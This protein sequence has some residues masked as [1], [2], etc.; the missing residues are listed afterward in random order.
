MG[1]QAET[2][3][4]ASSCP[5]A[6]GTLSLSGWGRSPQGLADPRAWTWP[7][8]PGATL[9]PLAHGVGSRA[10]MAKSCHGHGSFTCTVFSNL[11]STYIVGDLFINW[12][13]PNTLEICF[14]LPRSPLKPHDCP[15]R[16]GMCLLSFG[17]WPCSVAFFCNIS[18]GAWGGLWDA[19]YDEGCPLTPMG[20]PASAGLSTALVLS[21][22]SSPPVSTYPSW[23]VAAG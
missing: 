16:R 11:K 9:T 8:F 18:S 20:T 10:R 3:P 5:C 15:G 13:L 14:L 23:A 21:S 7:H 22:G 6:P 1:Y 4:P 17:H 2:P 19:W 12:F